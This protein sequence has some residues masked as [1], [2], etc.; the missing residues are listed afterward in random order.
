MVNS[1]EATTVK[2][3]KEQLNSIKE[4]I[5][6]EKNNVHIVDTLIKK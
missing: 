3:D 2:F 5:Q 6:K 1:G 4:S